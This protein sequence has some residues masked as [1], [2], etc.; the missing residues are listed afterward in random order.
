VGRANPPPC[1]VAADKDRGA[2]SASACR[3]MHDSG[4]VVPEH[5]TAKAVLAP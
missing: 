5:G 1:D 3:I 2:V 4:S